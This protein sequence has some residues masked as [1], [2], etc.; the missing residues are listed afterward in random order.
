M[1]IKND[2][3][4]MLI[5][6]D[7]ESSAQPNATYF[8]GVIDEVRIEQVVCSANWIHYDDAAQRDMVITYG[9]VTR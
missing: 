1:A 4:W 3:T 8:H 6:C 7:E 2:A 9:H 5:G